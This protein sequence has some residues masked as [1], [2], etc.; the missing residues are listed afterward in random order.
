MILN[1]IQA[2]VLKRMEGF[3]PEEPC[4]KIHKSKDNNSYF[5]TCGK[6]IGPVT[7]QVTIEELINALPNVAFVDIADEI[8]GEIVRIMHIDSKNENLII[9]L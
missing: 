1:T 4:I 3:N 2:D 7:N 6:Q 8:T 5:W 9:R